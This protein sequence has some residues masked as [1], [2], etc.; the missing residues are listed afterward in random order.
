VFVDH[1]EN[2]MQIIPFDSNNLPSHIRTRVAGRNASILSGI[3]G[4][5]YPVISIKGK[6]FAV[7]KGGERTVL[8]NPKDPDSPAT[9]IDAVIINANQGLA[10]VFY[11]KGYDP[12]ASEKQKPDCYSTDGLA[13]ASDAVNAQSKKCASCVHNHYGSAKQGKGKACS[14]TKRLAIAAV[15]Q[16]N[17]PMLLRIPPASLKSLGEFI[18]FLDNRGCD[19]DQVITKISFDMEAESPKL[20]FKALGILDDKT[21]ASVKEMAESEVVRDIVGGSMAVVHE[22]LAVADQ[23]A[24]LK[25]IEE[26]EEIPKPAKKVIAE[27]VEE[28]E[29]PKKKAVAKKKPVVEEEEFD[30]DG[31]NF[32]D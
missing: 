4:G 11:M 25:E 5:G 19:F 26:D 12:E 16:I 29:A 10:K 8:P 22:Q 21:A 27:P 30:L 6:V 20:T 31:I 23:K 9:S 18:K 17:E 28:E 2:K 14:D 24:I 32:D 3:G 13:P 1:K 15:D 7:V